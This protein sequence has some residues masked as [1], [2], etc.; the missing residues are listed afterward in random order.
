MIGTPIVKEIATN[1][2][3]RRVIIEAE[4]VNIP[5]S[6]RVI[7]KLAEILSSLFLKYMIEM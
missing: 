3:I 6:K 2:G 7:K 4:V 5:S 1:A